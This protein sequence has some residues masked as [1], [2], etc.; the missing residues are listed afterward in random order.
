MGSG[1]SKISSDDTQALQL[2]LQQ[3]TSILNQLVDNHQIRRPHAIAAIEAIKKISLFTLTTDECLKW[4]QANPDSIQ[5]ARQRT[6]N[7]TFSSEQIQKKTKTRQPSH[8]VFRSKETIAESL[9][10]TSKVLYVPLRTAGNGNGLFVAVC[11]ALRHCQSP[12][13]QS[14]F[15][16]VFFNPPIQ[17]HHLFDDDIQAGLQ[18][19]LACAD[20][21]DQERGPLDV[22]EQSIL[23]VQTDRL[24]S[25]DM[26]DAGS[27]RAAFSDASEDLLSI[28]K[29]IPGLKFRIYVGTETDVVPSIAGTWLDIQHNS[30]DDDHDDHD[31]HDDQVCTLYFYASGSRFSPLVNIDPAGKKTLEAYQATERTKTTATKPAEIH[32]DDHFETAEIHAE[33]KRQQ[34]ERIALSK[35]RKLEHRLCQRR[36][37]N[38]DKIIQGL[39][40][41]TIFNSVDDS[42]AAKL[43]GAME[44]FYF[45]VG[46]TICLQGQRA[47][48]CMY[49]L[50]GEISI[51]QRP[52]LGSRPRLIGT[53]GSNQLLGEVSLTKTKQYRGGTLLVTGNVVVQALVLGKKDFFKMVKKNVIPQTVLD[54]INA[55]VEHNKDKDLGRKVSSGLIDKILHKRTTNNGIGSSGGGTLQKFAMPN[56]STMKD[57]TQYV[58]EL[59]TVLSVDE[60]QKIVAQVKER[61][62][63]DVAQNVERNCA[64]AQKNLQNSVDEKRKHSVQRTKTRLLKR[65]RTQ[66]LKIANRSTVLRELSIFQQ[67]SSEH[68]AHFIAMSKRK[69]YGKGDLICGRGEESNHLYILTKGKVRVEIEQEPPKILNAVCVFGETALMADGNNHRTATCTADCVTELLQLNRMDFF[70]VCKAIDEMSLEKI[71]AEAV[72]EYGWERKATKEEQDDPKDEPK[73]EETSTATIL[74]DPKDEPKVEETSTTVITAVDE[75]A[76]EEKEY[77]KRVKAT[78]EEKRAV[79]KLAVGKDKWKKMSWR[80]R[81]N[82]INMHDVW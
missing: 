9:S 58:E 51:F 13:I 17:A 63:F 50:Q 73:V 74:D 59:T 60:Q 14:H 54:K 39:Q 79:A 16:T 35:K 43:L 45:D 36:L 52:K 27:I 53:V 76:L 48:N 4:I 37:K 56:G 6:S 46:S 3:E 47:K 55:Q 72:D 40:H 2:I 62:S 25:I 10:N 23:N 30:N 80:E 71:T 42:V 75:Y 19:R 5:F 82:A 68:L 24:R 38:T 41:T 29:M 67:L 11:L 26:Q 44:L 49:I 32:G 7:A 8:T 33:L 57:S 61:M 21:L 28:C 69:I 78:A 15:Q 12:A 34:L 77:R 66:Q 65:Q 1:T 18:I 64:A 70:Q 20:R 22:L 81:F 31:D